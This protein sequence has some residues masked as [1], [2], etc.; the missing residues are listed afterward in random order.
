MKNIILFLSILVLLGSATSCCRKMTSM[1]YTVHDTTSI[2]VRDRIVDTFIDR[3]T[4]TQI[5]EIGCDSFNKPFVRGTGI[6][7]G[8]RSTLTSFFE[9]SKLLINADCSALEIAIRVKDS[10]ISRLRSEVIISKSIIEKK[11]TIW[12]M[13]KKIGFYILYSVLLIL[14]WELILKPL[15]KSIKII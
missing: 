6:K 15:L 10:V 14:C 7:K 9:N 12:E 8:N 1:T 3:D 4:V 2:V 11:P 5:V 13:V